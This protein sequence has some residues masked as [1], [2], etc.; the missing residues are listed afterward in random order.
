MRRPIQDDDERMRAER[1]QMVEEQLI[2]R[3]IDDLRVVDAMR[4]VP[5]HLFLP[6]ELRDVAYL[7]RALAIGP[8]QTV[9]QPFV[10][11]LMLSALALEPRHRV[12][13]IGTGSGYQAALLGCL[14]ERV[15]SIEL[16]A[17]HARRAREVLETLGMENVEVRCADGYAGWPEAAP[18]DRIVLSAAPPEIPR[19]LLRQLARDGRMILPLGEER[20][21]LILLE[22][23]VSGLE[24]RELG[25]VRFV[26]MVPSTS[27]RM[28]S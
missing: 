3:H 14:T 23:G 16:S 5:R 28:I 6:R 17:S 4:E 25:A 15:Y 21:E 27:K 20:Q 22:R 2:A 7:D 11:A 18:F 26:P 13:E 9:S 19:T 1:S 24:S 10:V 12:L 8:Q